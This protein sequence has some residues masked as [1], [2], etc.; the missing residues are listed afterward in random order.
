MFKILINK[1]LI[2]LYDYLIGDSELLIRIYIC[3][4]VLFI[5]VK[6]NLRV[7]KVVFERKKCLFIYL[8]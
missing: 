3:L 5:V 1:L 7:I 6:G 8:I 2:F 4:F